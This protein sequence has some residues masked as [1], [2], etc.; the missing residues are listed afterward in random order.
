[1]WAVCASL[2]VLIAGISWIVSNT[3]SAATGPPACSPSTARD[4]FSAADH[5]PVVIS[6]ADSVAGHA[7][8]S[9]TGKVRLDPIYGRWLA[10]Y[11]KSVDL[12]P[13]TSRVRRAGRV[14]SQQF[15]GTAH[16]ILWSNRTSRVW[17]KRQPSLAASAFS[18]RGIKPQWDLAIP[19][20]W[21][22]AYYG[23]TDYGAALEPVN[24]SPTNSRQQQVFTD[25]TGTY[26]A[27]KVS[28]SSKASAAA[29]GMLFE[30]KQW[31]PIGRAVSSFDGAVKHEDIAKAA[32]YLAPGLA[33]R[34]ITTC[35]QKLLRFAG[36]PSRSHFAIR[37]WNDRSAEVKSVFSVSGHPVVD[38]LELTD[39]PAWG[40]KSV[41]NLRGGISN[42]ACP[43]W[44]P[45][46]NAYP[47]T[48]SVGDSIMVDAE[49]DLQEMG[50]TVDAAVSRQ[51]YAG[52]AILQQLKTEGELP[53]RVVIGLGTNGGMTES[54][55]DAGLNMLRGETR[56]V[57]LTVREPRSWQNQVNQI[58]HAVAK[59]FKNVRVADWFA[60]SAGH[61]GWFAP[62]GIHLQPEG[63]LAF[64][65]V[66]AD[67]LA[68]P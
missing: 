35:A 61:P 3:S 55:Y 26:A 43:P 12:G 29:P 66:I 52:I 57:I 9:P 27:N 36:W 28:W 42:P 34:V 23:G 6:N 39:S 7:L 14:W 22:S 30:K 68:E 50:I 56:V 32:R 48:Y 37:L 5:Q 60:F 31:Q 10:L 40:I 58:V 47:G 18:R 33:T 20:S 25:A 65:H 46:T 67:A 4:R 41:T 54:E 53:P 59:K 63:A 21:L 24:D 11:C 51:F 16:R 44:T 19:K 62:D 49:Y 8:R 1:M 13:A 17:V 64:S 2:L 15:A 38:N 45:P